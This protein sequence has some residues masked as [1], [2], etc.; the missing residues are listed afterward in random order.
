MI[1]ERYQGNLW[2]L[3]MGLASL[4]MLVLVLSDAWQRRRAGTSVDVRTVAAVSLLF[5]AFFAFSMFQVYI[6]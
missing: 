2:W 5:L 3:T 1:H 4:Y 6:H